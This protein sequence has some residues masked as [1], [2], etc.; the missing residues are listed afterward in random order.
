MSALPPIADVGRCIQVS[1]DQEPHVEGQEQASLSRVH[2][3]L[4][5]QAEAGG[6]DV[7]WNDAITPSKPDQP[8]CPCRPF[9][10]Q[11]LFL[12][13]RAQNRRSAIS[14]GSLRLRAHFGLMTQFENA[15]RRALSE[16]ERTGRLVR[17]AFVLGPKAQEEVFKVL[18]GLPATKTAET[19]YSTR[20]NQQ[21]SPARLT[22]RDRY[23]AEGWGPIP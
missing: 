11:G 1:K 5:G 17:V 21:A 8:E 3:Y 19:P 6:R 9:S 13:E 23:E 15:R 4:H 14:F 20:E 16:E 7:R 22:A 12:W 18:G 2:A 10:L